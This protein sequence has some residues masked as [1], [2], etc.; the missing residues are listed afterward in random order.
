MKRCVAIVIAIALSCIPASS[1]AAI[2]RD[3]ASKINYNWASGPVVATWS[4]TVTTTAPAFLVL[5]CA[6]APGGHNI[7]SATYAGANLTLDRSDHFSGSTFEDNFLLTLSSPAT[8]TN[9]IIVTA[10]TGTTN[11][12]CGAVDYIDTAAG[13]PQKDASTFA[14]SSSGSFSGSIATSVNNDWLVGFLGES[15]HAAV[16]AGSNTHL[17]ISAQPDDPW[18]AFLDT[19]G[20]QT[21]AGSHTMQG[22]LA[23]SITWGFSIMALKPFSAAPTTTGALPRPGTLPQSLTLC[24]TSLAIGA[25]II[26]PRKKDA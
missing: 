8:G 10:D 19:N 23:S 24:I 4:H 20:A 12:Y 25:W 15:P 13:P 9:N 26:Y 21:P 14:S 11:V 3:A 17:V 2:S 16:T 22:T 6:L 7:I 18:W 5:G 1:F